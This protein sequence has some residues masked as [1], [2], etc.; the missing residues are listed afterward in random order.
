MADNGLEDRNMK[1]TWKGQERKATVII[2]A[3]EKLNFRR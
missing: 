1:N 3:A 2:D